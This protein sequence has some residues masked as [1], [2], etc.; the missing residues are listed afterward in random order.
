MA[1]RSTLSPRN[2]SRSYDCARCSAHDVCVK[3]CA[4]RSGGSDST[5]ATRSRRGRSSF[6]L[7][8]RRDVVDSLTDGLD[9]LGVLVRDLHAELVFELHDQLDEVEG[10]G[11]EILLERGLFRD[12]ALLDPELLDQDVLDLLVDLLPGSCHR[13]FLPAFR[14]SPAQRSADATTE[15]RLRHVR[16]DGSKPALPRGL[17]RPSPRAGSRWRT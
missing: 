4:S 13:G 1:S 8:V 15:S 11:V 14:R 12:L 5:S 10:I 17:G 6:A 7:L 3:T 2:S 16:R 9:L